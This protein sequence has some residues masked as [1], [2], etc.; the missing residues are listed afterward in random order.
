M[1]FFFSN[2]GPVL[3]NKIPKCT[4]H[5][6]PIII[7]DDDEDLRQIAK[8]CYGQTNRVN[9]LV[10]LKSGLELVQY[11][12]QVIA[13]KKPSPEVILLDL[14]MY[15]LDGIQTLSKLRSIPSFE[16]GPPIII[17]SVS[18]NKNDVL[19]ASKYGANGYKEKPTTPR[20]YIQFFT[21]I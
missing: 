11:M 2:S 5:S 8:I 20:E 19:K 4:L 13:N 1:E 15:G 17:L 16:Q 7:V 21:Q 6:G 14:N 18:T 9:E 10:L 12:E 3:I